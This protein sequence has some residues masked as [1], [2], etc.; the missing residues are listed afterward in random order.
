MPASRAGECAHGPYRGTVQLLL[1]RHALPRRSEPG[2]GSDPDLSNEGVEQA[3]RLPDALKR[4]PITH[5]VSSPQ[6]RAVQ[7]GQPVAAALGLPVEID[8]R[9]AEY[10]RDLAQYIPV[11]QLAVENPEELKRLVA[12]QLPSGVDES[13]FLTRTRAAID[14][15]VAKG[16]HEDT[17]AVFSHAGVINALLHQILGT[18]RLLSFHVDYA[19]ITR[20]L[21]SRSTG[22]LAVGGVNGIEHVWDLL[23]RNARW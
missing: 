23:P 1:V 11:E 12:G 13:A 8:A 14:D 4:F 7:T 21:S 15:L 9:L 2:Q 22:R 3:Q 17:V 6:R 20:L 19:S 5:V 18:E 10:D 16:E